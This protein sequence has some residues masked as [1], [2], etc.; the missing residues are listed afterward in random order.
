M[1]N[2]EDL[3]AGMSGSEQ[4]GVIACPAADVQDPPD[5]GV[6]QGK[7]GRIATVLVNTVQITG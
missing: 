6:E 7:Q 4:A 5:P 1:S 3:A 2:P